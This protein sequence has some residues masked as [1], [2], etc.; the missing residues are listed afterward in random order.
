MQAAAFTAENEELKRA[1]A[2]S[3]QLLGE[4]EV[5]RDA[6]ETANSLKSTFLA[7]MSHEMRTPLGVILGFGEFLLD[8]DLSPKD[9][10]DCVNTIMRNAR[11]LSNL[12]NEVLD[13]AKIEANK[14]EIETIR[15]YLQSFIDGIRQSMASQAQQKGVELSIVSDVVH[16]V[17]ATDPTLLRQVLFNV[18]GNAIKFTAAGSVDVRIRM[19]PG[20]TVL[21][22]NVKDTGIG[23]APEHT[24]HIWTPFT[25]ADNTT[26]RRFGGTGL[27]LSIAQ[28]TASALGGTLILTESTVGVGSTFKLLIP[29]SVHDQPESLAT[30]ATSEASIAGCRIL[31]VDDAEDNRLFITKFLTVAGA[32][33]EEAVNGEEGVKMALVGR[34]DVI[35][36]DVQMPIMD[37][38]EA[39]VYLRKNS[40][41]GPILA[42]TANA[43][44]GER[45]QSLEIGFT[46]YM[47]KPVRRQQLI[48]MVA[49]LWRLN[50]EVE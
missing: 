3:V 24:A 36:M 8:P 26:T 18:I 41:R 14:L 34:Y 15:F 19:I 38:N 5:E 48:A 22:I 23:I 49:K 20:T 39:T 6:A 2:T 27:G 13:L 1:T 31:L 32:T 12:V 9:R 28:K 44:K 50:T 10:I 16:K 47:T 46:D 29:V 30:P 4:L 40:Y 43:M 42:L 45:E 17:V 37:G 7:N 35:I 25:Q 11:Q 21:E 33:V